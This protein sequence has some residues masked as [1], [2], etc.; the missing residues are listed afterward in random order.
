MKGIVEEYVFFGCVCA[1]CVCAC[2]WACVCVMS[3]MSMMCAKRGAYDGW[4]GREKQEK[5]KRI[6][7]MEGWKDGGTEANL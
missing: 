5:K 4:M 6:G 1:M 3:C 2:G 7:R